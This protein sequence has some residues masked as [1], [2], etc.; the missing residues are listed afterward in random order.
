MEM[1]IEA[2]M[3]ALTDIRVWSQYQEK[4]FSFAKHGTGNAVVIAVA[5]SGKTTTLVEAMKGILGSIF[6]AFN[7]VIQVELSSRGVNAKTFHSLCYGPV[8]RARKARE[9]KADK[10][11]DVINDRLGDDESRLYS[12]FL[13]K[14]VGLGKNAGIGCL[15]EDTEQNWVDLA[16]HHDL[17][18]DSEKADYSQAIRYAS[19]MLKASNASQLLDFDDLLYLAVKDGIQ[20]PKFDFVVVDEAQDTNAI[21]RAVIRKIMKPT[22]RLMAVGDPAQAI[23][24]FRGADS[25]AINLIKEE[26]GAIELPLT[27]SY[28]C[29]KSVVKYAQ[30]WVKHIEHHENAPEGIVKSHDSW[31]LK[32]FAPS[33]LVVSRTTAPMVSLAFKLL[34]AHIPAQILGRDIGAGLK[35]LIKRM[36]AKGVDALEEKI[37]AWSAREIEKALAKRQEAQAEAIADKAHAIRFLIRS[38]LETDRTVPALMGLIDSLFADKANAVTLST[39]HKSKGLEANQVFW[40]NSSKCPAKWAKQAWQQEQERNLCYVATTRAKK[41]LHLIEDLDYTDKVGDQTKVLKQEK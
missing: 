2:P 30:Q 19:L 27:V 4:I 10:M 16:S 12:A 24:G 11:R 36:N 23:Y 29:P 41:E 33:D 39:I 13:V 20:L 7:K 9:V 1:T 14:L 21:Q 40:L 26:F 34:R 17:E 28:R 32:V 5:G 38:L 6:L 22:S 8:T 18:L 35:A 3:T 37:N 25:N 31:D 15:I